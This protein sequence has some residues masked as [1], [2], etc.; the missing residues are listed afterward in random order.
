MIV[1]H[2][3]ELDKSRIQIAFDD[4]DSLVLYKKEA[5]HLE[6]EP[7]MEWSEEQYQ[8]IVQEVLIPRARKRAMH[9]LE[10]MDR[11]E[12]QLREK[13]KQ[14]Q[15]PGEVIEDAIAYVK[16]FHYVDD[17]RYACNYVRYRCQSKS[18]RML[19]LELSQKGI[20]RELAERALEEEYMEQDETFQIQ[21]WVQKKQYD[22]G[23]ADAKQKQKMYQFLLRKGFR[24]EDILRVI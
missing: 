23:Q 18:R 9:L 6:L 12:A 21:K 14:G 22:R 17:F 19:M 15:Y 8:Q 20:S 24:S 7:E 10:K 5:R 1:K 16:R 3:E 2:V 4:A 13:L 11:T